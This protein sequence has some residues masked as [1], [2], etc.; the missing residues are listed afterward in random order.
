M[1]T[2]S[3]HAIGC[4]GFPEGTENPATCGVV[5]IAAL[6]SGALPRT[7]ATAAGNTASPAPVASAVAARGP[8]VQTR[9]SGW[10]GANRAASVPS[11]PARRW[12][13]HAETWCGVD[14]VALLLSSTDKR[15]VSRDH[16]CLRMVMRFFGRDRVRL[17]R[18]RSGVTFWLTESRV[19]PHL[20][21]APPTTHLS[22]HL[23]L[24]SSSLLPRV[25]SLPWLLSLG[26]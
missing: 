3:S 8:V 26:V 6:H 9:A 4:G 13:L 24:T 12:K 18:R 2:R 11:V 25:L 19:P 23:L 14:S 15:A 17:R 22:N 21:I 16:T 7:R 1:P 10:P 5:M 20:L